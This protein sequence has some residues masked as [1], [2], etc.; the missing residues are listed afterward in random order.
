[1]K[2]AFIGLGTMGG[3]MAG[4]IQAAGYDLRV[5][6]RSPVRSAQWLAS[7]GGEC[8]STIAEAVDGADLVLT[9]LSSDPATR[10]VA[11]GRHGI[12]QQ[13]K[14]G[15]IFVDHGSG[16]PA[17]ARAMAKEA[18]IREITFF[19]A[20]V[21]GGSRAAKS[22]TLAIIAG[23]TNETLARVEPVFRHYAASIVAM[24]IIDAGQMTKLVNVVIG[25]GTS[26]A[27]AEGLSF[28]M[29]AGLDPHKVV[30]ILMQGSSR[31]WILEHRARSMIDRDYNALY[32]LTMARK[33]LMNVRAEGLESN[34]ILPVTSLVEQ[35]VSELQKRGFGGLDL[36]SLV[37]FFG[38]GTKASGV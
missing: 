6:N 28:A 19:D 12:L 38:P 18:S 2:V 26:L 9:C 7:N 27:I 8:A 32:S 15:A 16:A 25:Q 3:P 37:E 35:I 5:F 13:M 22:G 17:F 31:S 4:H 34:A 1:M 36:S 10:E 24:D 29:A 21:S 11:H 23:T 33:D 20:P 14:A 30:D